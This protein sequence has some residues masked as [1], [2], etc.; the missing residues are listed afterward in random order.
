MNGMMKHRGITMASLVVT[1]VVSRALI[2]ADSTTFGTC[3]PN[4][5]TMQ[6][7]A[8]ANISCTFEQSKLVPGL[9]PYTEEQSGFRFL[10][11]QEFADINPVVPANQS[12]GEYAY[13]AVVG[14]PSSLLMFANKP[15]EH[16][17]D[18]MWDQIKGNLLK[19][20]W[21][22]ELV[23]K[24][25]GMMLLFRRDA[26]STLPETAWLETVSKWKSF[27][28]EA[29]EAELR[30]R[31]TIDAGHRA[32]VM[33]FHEPGW[34]DKWI[35]IL[36]LDENDGVVLI[37]IMDIREKDWELLQDR[38]IRSINSVEWSVD[39][40]KQALLNLTRTRAQNGD[41]VAQ[42]ELGFA[43]IF[44]KGIK[45]DVKEGMGWLTRSGDNEY[46]P[47]QY[48]LGLIYSGGKLL[49]PNYEMAANWMLKA[50]E[51]G[52]AEAQY[53]MGVFYEHGI[54]VEPNPSTAKMWY[55][56]S[57]QQG[58]NEAVNRLKSN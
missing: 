55:R 6:D 53:Q 58:H 36:R 32:L 19:A 14:T 9:L 20:P 34:I 21:N 44:E 10:F 2:A 26:W 50:A 27:F 28:Q 29:F 38:A 54:G 51:S 43:Y 15:G 48:F 18:L 42:F 5:G 11:P 47:A 16:L 31:Y 13:G 23:P 8:T 49:K 35:H 46:T 1:M 56:K 41:R 33:L 37:T 7:N 3:S 40:V 52:D 17:K 30:T 25:N 24:A 12:F 57:A 39:L 4:I 22:Q 45:K